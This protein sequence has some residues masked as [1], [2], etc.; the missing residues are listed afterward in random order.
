MK[1]LEKLTLNLEELSKTMHVIS[2][3]EKK[4]FVGGAVSSFEA[5]CLQNYVLH[6]GDVALTD[7][8]F[9]RILSAAGSGGTYSWKKINGVWY[10]VRVVSFYENDEFNAALGT[11][12]I[13]YDEDGYAVAFSDTYDFNAMPQG[14]RDELNELWTNIGSFIP[15]EAYDIVYGDIW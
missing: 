7:N 8:E 5:F 12:T 4:G 13:Y 14:E 3:K 2:E 15:G 9:D 10:E 6:G 1:K 11:A